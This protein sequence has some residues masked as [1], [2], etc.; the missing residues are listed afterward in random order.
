MLLRTIIVLL[1]Q[2]PLAAQ[3]TAIS[4]PAYQ[5]IT[6]RVTANQ[7]SFS[8]YQDADSGF[9]HG[10]FAAIPNA[11]GVLVN[12]AC[13]DNAA[14]MTTGCATNTN[15]LDTTRGTVLSITL[16]PSTGTFSGVNIQEP[17]DYPSPECLSPPGLS[18]CGYDL[19]PAAGVTTASTISFN[20]RS[21]NGGSFLFGVGNCVTA[22]SMHISTSWTPIV[23]PLS[24]LVIPGS[25]G[26]ACQPQI[27]D[28]SILFAVQAVAPNQGVILL[29]NIVFNPD[30]ARQQSSYSFPL[31][32]QTFGV[33]P[34]PAPDT[35]NRPLWPIPPDQ[36]NRNATSIYES[37][38]A[39]IALLA[40]RQGQDLV[41]AKFL[42]DTFHAALYNDNHGDPVPTS[43]NSTQGCYGGVAASQCGLHDDYESGDLALNSTQPPPEQGQA[44][45]D[46]LAGFGLPLQANGTYSNTCGSSNFCLVNDGASGGNNA[47]A[48]LGLLAAYRQFKNVQYLNDAITVGNWI[49]A[50]LRDTSQTGFGGYF[51]GYSA[52]GTPKTLSHSKSVE[53]NADIFAAFSELAAVENQLRNSAAAASWN[54]AAQTASTFVCSLYDQNLGGFDAGTLSAGQKSVW[55]NQTPAQGVCPNAGRQSGDDIPNTC[56]FLDS[57]TFTTLALAGSSQCGATFDWRKPIEHVLSTFLQPSVTANGQTLQGFNIVPTPSDNLAAGVAWEFTGQV[58]DTLIYLDFILGQTTFLSQANSYLQQIAKAQTSDPFGDSEGLVASTLQGV[59]NLPPLDQCLA[60]PYQCIPER[61]GLAATAWG[62]FAE[63]GINPE[64]PLP[65]LTATTTVLVS[66]S[67]PSVAGQSVT[68]TALVSSSAATGTVTFMDG[69]ILLGTVALNNNLNSGTATLA[70]STLSAGTH[71]LTALYSS[72][73]N[74]A[75]SSGTLTQTVTPASYTI[76]GQVIG[77]GSSIATIN[78]TGSQTTSTT[79][80][81][82]NYSITLAAG[83]TYTVAPAATDFT[84]APVSQTF[85]NLSS[86]QTMNFTAIPSN[87]LELHT[88]TPCRVVDTRPTAGFPS[89]FGPPTMSGGMTRPF[90]IPSGS[91]GIS[92]TAIAYSFNVTVVPKGYLGF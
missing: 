54:S 25:G 62:I 19:A 1:L 84:F 65:P 88:V 76:S 3:T 55:G 11:N 71:L 46:R 20:A 17:Q 23:I 69:S 51:T 9:N 30:P 81:A 13:I 21:P 41:N 77:L 18:A 66:S 73:S 37:S 44:G 26:S 15:V 61:V 42:A 22:T 4:G 50:N 78:V 43:P 8:I 6:S 28:L 75:G 89:T 83:G 53:N 63:Q 74:Y 2:L 58:V 52:G 67:N 40:R 60:T 70:V 47:Y 92:S 32:T 39:L 48:I 45:D 91:C 82:G 24:T 16:T 38:L 7:Q 14:N 10:F 49:M 79:S 56:D 64:V 31:S 72:D 80:A 85:A 57:D 5:E 36:V 35:T 86:N 87:G 59:A 12:A 34:V 29:D 90:P 27:S 33:I 68:L